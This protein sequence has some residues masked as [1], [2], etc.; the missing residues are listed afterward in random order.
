MGF[1]LSVTIPD[2]AEFLADPARRGVCRG[3][4]WADTITDEKHVAVRTSSRSSSLSA[5]PTALFFSLPA[6]NATVPP[7]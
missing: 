7:L 5:Y 2:V 3:T 4:V 6:V 1:G